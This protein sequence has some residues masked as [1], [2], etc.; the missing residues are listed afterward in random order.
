MCLE[1][2]AFLF[3]RLPNPIFWVM[4]IIFN[5]F[6]QLLLT[7]GNEDICYY[8]FHCAN[9]LGVLSSFNNVFSNSGYVLLGLLFILIVYI[10]LVGFIQPE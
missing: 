2:I 10:R 9:P 4:Y 1:H 5:Y 3:T 6:L 7:S 8:N